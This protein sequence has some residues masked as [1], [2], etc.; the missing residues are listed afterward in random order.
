MARSRSATPCTRVR[1][2]SGLPTIG[3]STM[4][5]H[6]TVNATVAGSSPATRTKYGHGIKAVPWT[7]NP[8]MSVQL[9]LS[10]PIA[11]AKNSWGILGD[12]P[13]RRFIFRG[14]FGIFHHLSL[15]RGGLSLKSP[16]SRTLAG[17][18]MAIGLG[19]GAG[20]TVVWYN[21]RR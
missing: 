7:P 10:V 12:R 17:R 13:L 9:R 20:V 11:G 15:A 21:M 5:V 8:V 2:P 4:V 3:C 19:G 16:I 1:T 6:R 18:T 14:R